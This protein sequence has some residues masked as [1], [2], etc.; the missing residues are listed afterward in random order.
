MV[1]RLIRRILGH[2]GHNNLRFR[3]IKFESLACQITNIRRNMRFFAIGKGEIL[4]RLQNPPLIFRLQALFVK[5]GVQIIFVTAFPK[6]DFGKFFCQKLVRLIL[7]FEPFSICGRFIRRIG[8]A[9]FR[10]FAITIRIYE[11]GKHNHNAFHACILQCL[12]M[13]M[14]LRC[15]IGI[16]VQSV[17]I[18]RAFYNM[19][20]AHP[21]TLAFN[22]HRLIKLGN[23]IGGYLR[24]AVIAFA[25]VDIFC[26]TANTEHI[27]IAIKR[28]F[29]DAYRL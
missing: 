26:Q 16:Y 7:H 24:I 27:L 18:V 12:K 11:T 23:P 14:E 22:A 19:R 17:G 6:C 29:F 3:I 13:L 9:I 1:V 4:C 10:I 20:N 21:N 15:Q 25:A 5:E 2:T 28:K 8:R